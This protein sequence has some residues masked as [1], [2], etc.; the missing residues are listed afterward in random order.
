MDEQQLAQLRS[1]A[2]RLRSE[3]DT[4]ELKAA[5]RALEL[6]TAEIER[7]R[8]E[9]AARKSARSEPIDDWTRPAPGEQV[10]TGPRPFDAESDE[11]DWRGSTRGTQRRRRSRPRPQALPARPCASDR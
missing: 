11:P 9:L 1:W 6:A 8:A 10:D 7:L 2:E 4:H 3:G 5:G